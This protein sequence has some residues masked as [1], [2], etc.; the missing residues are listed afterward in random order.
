MFL[1]SVDIFIACQSKATLGMGSGGA[2]AFLTVVE[3]GQVAA[4]AKEKAA[5]ETEKACLWFP[6]L[7]RGF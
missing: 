4:S 6:P 2:A 5:N 3:G 1:L 7:F